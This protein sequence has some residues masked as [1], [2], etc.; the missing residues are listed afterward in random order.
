MGVDVRVV[1]GAGWRVV[2]L[3]VGVL[4]VRV[5]IG[6]RVLGM[7]VGVRLVGG[8]CVGEGTGTRVAGDGAGVEGV[9][10]LGAADRLAR[11]PRVR[12]V[13]GVGVD[14]VTAFGGGFGSFWNHAR[15]AANARPRVA[16]N[17]IAPDIAG[18]ISSFILLYLDS[19]GLPCGP[20]AAD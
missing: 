9:E 15:Y 6:G 8:G 3:T 13:D 11:G 16:T 12:L 2:G 14:H 17:A 10:G 7:G 19:G 1:V 20:V 5:G 4:T 18:C